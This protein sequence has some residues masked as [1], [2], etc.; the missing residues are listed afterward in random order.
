MSFV[1]NGSEG[2]YSPVGGP[3]PCSLA[4]VSSEELHAEWLKR[5]DRLSRSKR[6][7]RKSP[8][9]FPPQLELRL[10]AAQIRREDLEREGSVAYQRNPTPFSST[11]FQQ[12][13]TAAFT[14]RFR[15][16][17]EETLAQLRIIEDGK[18]AKH[19]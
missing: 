15:Q 3:E 2:E 4:N 17:T 10:R 5:C 13:A 18:Q 9:E 8:Q 1:D 16:F 11:P 14:N 12:S 19:P 7:G 6:T